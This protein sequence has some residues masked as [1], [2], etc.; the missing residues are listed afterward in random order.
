M[1]AMTTALTPDIAARFAAVALGHVAREYPNKP[2]H[3]LAGP[4]D[5]RTPAALH[6][7]FHG[8]YDWHSCVHGTW[9]LA[10]VLRLYPDGRTADPEEQHLRD[11]LQIRVPVALQRRVDRDA[12]VGRDVQV[13]PL[14]GAAALRVPHRR[15]MEIRHVDIGAAPPQRA[16]RVGRQAAAVE[17]PASLAR[18]GQ[19]AE[20]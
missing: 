16:V 18:P 6:P 8:S 3:V 4:A 17:D 14:R 13:G 12:V 9:L 2:G 20:L 10:R 19:D 1:P 11:R 15:R 7:A 5:A